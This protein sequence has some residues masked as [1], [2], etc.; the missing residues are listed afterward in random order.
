MPQL[1]QQILVLCLH[2]PNLDAGIGA[3]AFFDGTGKVDPSTGSTDKPPYN[4]ALDAMRDG[5]R[6]MQFPQQ[7]PAFPGMEYNTS[8]LKFEYIL[9]KMV[10]V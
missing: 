10:E 5:W 1:R 3:W 7:F 2:S 8:F 4:S 9:E 6:V